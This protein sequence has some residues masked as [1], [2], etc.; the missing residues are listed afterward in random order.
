LI[1]NKKLN[2][3][4]ITNRLQFEEQLRDAKNKARD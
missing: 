2:D 1:E 4:L 3:L